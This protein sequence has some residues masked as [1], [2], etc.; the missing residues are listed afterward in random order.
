MLSL[1]GKIKT[2]NEDYRLLANPWACG[3]IKMGRREVGCVQN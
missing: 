3:Y 1:L 2:C